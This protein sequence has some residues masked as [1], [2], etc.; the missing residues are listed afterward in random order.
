MA[1]SSGAKVI[2]DKGQFST[3]PDYDPN[4]P[5]TMQAYLE[6]PEYATLDKVRKTLNDL[7]QETLEE[8]D[9]ER[10]DCYDSEI[11]LKMAINE[12]TNARVT[13]ASTIAQARGEIATAKATIDYAK[14]ELLSLN[15]LLVKHNF[16]CANTLKMARAKKTIIEH[17]YG[18]AKTVE[19]MVDCDKMAADAATLRR[20][21]SRSSSRRS[22]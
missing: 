13:L 11:N 17:D 4:D 3:P 14:K 16:E 18:V 8:Q 2:V 22:R 19:D 12:N 1:T 9:I 15:A 7:Y 20:S 6:K 21:S 10:A 5:S